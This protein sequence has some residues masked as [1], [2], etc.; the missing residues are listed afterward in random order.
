MVRQQQQLFWEQRLSASEY[1]AHPFYGNS[2]SLWHSQHSRHGDDEGLEDA[3]QSSFRNHPAVYQPVSIVKR[4]HYP[5]CSRP[6][7]S[8][9][10]EVVGKRNCPI[11]GGMKTFGCILYTCSVNALNYR[12]YACCRKCRWQISFFTYDRGTPVPWCGTRTTV[13]CNTM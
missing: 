7:H 1:T 13:A 6:Q 10:A 2:Q 3:W 9:D 12:C 4:W 11:N 8:A 5:S